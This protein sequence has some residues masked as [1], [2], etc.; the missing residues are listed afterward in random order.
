VAPQQLV[1]N[2]IQNSGQIGDEKSEKLATLLINANLAFIFEFYLP[3]GS[4]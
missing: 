1:E 3:G 2:P 4:D